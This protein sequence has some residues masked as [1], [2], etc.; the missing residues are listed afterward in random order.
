MVLEYRWTLESGFP[1]RWSKDF[2]RFI[3]SFNENPE[4]NNIHHL[5]MNKPETFQN[6]EMEV[7]KSGKQGEKNKMKQNISG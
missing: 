6:M 7:T 4:S 5:I 2:F 1:N 3:H